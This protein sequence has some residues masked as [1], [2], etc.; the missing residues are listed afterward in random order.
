LL[1]ACSN[2]GGANASGSGGGGSTSGGSVGNG[3]SITSNVGGD[4][5]STGGD[6]GSGG[7]TG[8]APAC[9]SGDGGGPI[10][11]GGGGGQLACNGSG[12]RFVTRVV[13]VCYGTG[14]GFG[15]NK[16]PQIVYGPP[17]GAGAGSG[18]LDVLALGEG[19]SITV[20]FADN[21]IVD[22]PGPDFIVFENPF[23]VGGDPDDVYANPGTVSVSDDGVHW[24]DFPCKATAAP[25]GQCAGWHPV[26][27]NP[28]NDVDPLDPKKAGGDAF[29]LADIGVA[30][31]RFVKITDRAD[32]S[33]DFDLDA[34]AIVNAAC[35]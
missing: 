12:S 32:L 4:A 16:F 6:G 11:D 15:Q 1:A 9:R 8:G 5:S 20:T 31:A 33:G 19:G 24:T 17:K 23:E 22:G 21:A 30:R 25:W 13:E 2:G 28:D 27:A 14:A 29:D 18:S 3:G 35:P 7:A 10:G 34:V 26:Y